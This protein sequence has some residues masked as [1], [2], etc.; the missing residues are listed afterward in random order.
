MEAFSASSCM[1]FLLSMT[2]RP[3]L[4]ILPKKGSG[5]EQPLWLLYFQTGVAQIR[6][7]LLAQPGGGIS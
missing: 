7:L 5:P 1:Y 3:D 4:V 2:V 6:V